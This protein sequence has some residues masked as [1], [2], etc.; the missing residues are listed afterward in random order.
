MAAGDENLEIVRTVVTLAQN[1]GMQ[2]VAEGIETAE[3][4][5]LLKALRCE[6]GQGFFFSHALPA[7][8]A[9]ELLHGPREE[10]HKTFTAKHESQPPL[11]LF[12]GYPM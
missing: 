3:Q 6:Y 5:A 12:D 9:A 7:A 1:L 4:L 10:T 11:E 8:E 2:V